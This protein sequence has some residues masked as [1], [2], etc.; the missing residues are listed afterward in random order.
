MIEIYSLYIY[1]SYGTVCIFAIIFM[2]TF[3]LR[4]Y[5]HLTFF[6]RIATLLLAE[7]DHLN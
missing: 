6:L 7:I 3:D 1:Y 4:F 5:L 2:D